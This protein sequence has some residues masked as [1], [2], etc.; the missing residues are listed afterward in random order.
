MKR[1]DER[2]VFLFSG[3]ALLFVGMS[4]LVSIWAG[5]SVIGAVLVLVPLMSL[6]RR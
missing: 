4:G 5:C 2:D 6:R 3:L 1:V